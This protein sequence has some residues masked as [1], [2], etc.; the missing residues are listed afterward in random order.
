MSDQYS[1][2]RFKES[3]LEQSVKEDIVRTLTVPT[4]WGTADFSS[5]TCYLYEDPSGI[6]DNI[7][8]ELSGSASSSGQVITFKKILGSSLV[9]EK[10]YRFEVVFTT[11]EG[12]KLCGWGDFRATR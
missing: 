1:K 3:P 5:I 11:S 4:D 7:S 9:A 2:R 12:N 6:E 10:D 8:D